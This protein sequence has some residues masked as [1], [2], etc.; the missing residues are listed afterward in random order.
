MLR[1]T[2]QPLYQGFGAAVVAF[3]LAAIS[4]GEHVSAHVHGAVLPSG[5]GH[6]H[7]HHC[8]IAHHW[9]QRHVTISE[10]V[11]TYHFAII[12]PIEQLLLHPARVGY[13]AHIQAAVGALLHAQRNQAAIGVGHCAGCLPK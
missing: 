4:A 6:L 11:M 2:Q 7:Q 8:A 3:V 1:L 13:A 12:H 9:H 5:T 10:Q